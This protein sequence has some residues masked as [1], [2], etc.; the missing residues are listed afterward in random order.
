MKIITRGVI[1]WATSQVLEEDF[2]EYEGPVAQ[3]KD[4][5]SPPQP[6]NPWTQ[7]AAQY[8][9]STGTAAYNAGLNRTN[10]VNPLGGSSWS[11]T[12]G[13]G[14]GAPGMS[15]PTGPTGALPGTG[16]NIP[17]VGVGGSGGY[18]SFGGSPT[19]SYGGSVGMG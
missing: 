19:W 10:Q 9:L 8:G 12:G 15:P 1:D 13:S 2:Y 7:A 4:A 18:Q 14:Y 6:V 17:Q 11:S 5:G 16:Y 3:C